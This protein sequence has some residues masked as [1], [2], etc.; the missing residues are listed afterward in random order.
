MHLLY[1]S[2]EFLDYV[3]TDLAVKCF[4]LVSPVEVLVIGYITLF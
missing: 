1:H 3:V 4:L 2:L